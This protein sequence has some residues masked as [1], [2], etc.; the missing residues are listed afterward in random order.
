MVWYRGEPCG[1]P[2]TLDLILYCCIGGIFQIERKAV[3]ILS[4][5]M[6]ILTSLQEVMSFLDE[7][8]REE[9]VA[10]SLENRTHKL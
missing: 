10:Y 9:A 6:A 5:P 4:C 8:V 7:D 1:G 2:T 3:P